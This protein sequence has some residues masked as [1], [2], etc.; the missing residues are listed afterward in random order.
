[1]KLPASYLMENLGRIQEILE[2]DVP[3]TSFTFKSKNKEIKHSP[4]T[5]MF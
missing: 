3:K 1:M 4:N 2:T 5:R